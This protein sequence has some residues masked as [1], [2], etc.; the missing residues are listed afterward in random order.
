MKLTFTKQ[1][2]D[3][4]NE[5]ECDAR[6]IVGDDCIW[7]DYAKK[8]RHL[9]QY[10]VE[11]NKD[12]KNIFDEPTEPHYDVVR[13]DSVDAGPRHA[14]QRVD[15]MFNTAQ[16]RIIAQR[17]L[18]GEIHQKSDGYLALSGKNKAMVCN[19][20]GSYTSN[21]PRGYRVM[22]PENAI[23]TPDEIAAIDEHFNSAKICL[24][25]KGDFYNVFEQTFIA[26]LKLKGLI[27]RYNT[28]WQ[29]LSPVE[30]NRIHARAASLKNGS[31]KPVD[32]A[33]VDTK[34]IYDFFDLE[35]Y[36]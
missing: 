16:C 36:D 12:Y 8:L 9:V 23:C 30:R 6:A 34:R 26:E 27:D 17:I 18:N 3:L 32:H 2:L 11:E 33:L 1:I 10:D 7:I 35:V 21:D 22:K 20:K 14:K 15:T 25:I 19:I 29:A 31:I 13:I 4:I 28:H 24:T 5:L